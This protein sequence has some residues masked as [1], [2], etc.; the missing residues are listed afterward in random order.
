[1]FDYF[2]KLKASD[3]EIITFNV[4]PWNLWL[5]FNEVIKKSKGGRCSECAFTTK[6]DWHSRQNF[7]T[8]DALGNDLENIIEK[9]SKNITEEIFSEVKLVLTEDAEGNDQLH[10]GQERKRTLGVCHCRRQRPGICNDIDID[11]DID[12]GIDIDIGY[13]CVIVGV[14]DQVDIHVVPNIDVE[15]D[16]DIEGYYLKGNKY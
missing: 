13:G 15:I 10:V 11:I 5:D 6:K 14:K 16:V 8:Y 4:E 2:V 9:L 3:L 12:F 1:M 7:W